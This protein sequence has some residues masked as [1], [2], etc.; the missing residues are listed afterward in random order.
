MQLQARSAHSSTVGALVD[1]VGQLLDASFAHWREETR[2]GEA[3]EQ[4]QQLARAA[5]W[6]SASKQ[7]ASAA[8]RPE[9]EVGGAG[10]G[11][12]QGCPDGRFGRQLAGRN[13]WLARGRLQQHHRLARP[14]LQDLVAGS[15]KQQCENAWRSCQRPASMSSVGANI[16]SVNPSDNSRLQLASMHLPACSGAALC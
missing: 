2:G 8:A 13:S 1:E 3:A 12:Q 15:D 14:S 6:P 4:A 7:P 9:A 10:C 11:V 5:L 16:K